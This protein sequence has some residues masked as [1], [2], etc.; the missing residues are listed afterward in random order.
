MPD[1][2]GLRALVYNSL[3]RCYGC[4]AHRGSAHMNSKRPGGCPI[5]QLLAAA[6]ARREALREVREALLHDIRVQP[7][8]PIIARIDAALEEK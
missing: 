2:K 4:G 5:G 1:A 6:E 7:E 3:D 8:E